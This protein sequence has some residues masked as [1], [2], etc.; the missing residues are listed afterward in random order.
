LLEEYSSEL[1]S[2]KAT[3]SP[4]HLP[5][6]QDFDETPIEQVTYLHLLGAL[7]YLTKSRP[8]IATAVSFA[9]VF[10]AMPTAGAYVEL[11]FCLKYLSCTKDLGLM[12]KLGESNRELV[13]TCYVDASYFGGNTRVLKCMVSWCAISCSV[14]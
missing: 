4:Q 9:S 3:L 12:L 13:L 10:A 2:I 11:L 5:N 14:A 7:I 6:L 8:D 1:A